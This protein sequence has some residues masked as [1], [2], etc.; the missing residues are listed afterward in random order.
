[1]NNFNKA[2]EF[3]EEKI[4]NSE[5]ITN[6]D[7][8]DVCGYEQHYCSKIFQKYANMNIQEYIKRRK[9]SFA[10]GDLVT[11][12]K[13]IADIAEKYLYSADGFTKAFKDTFGITPIQLKRKEKTEVLID[14]F[15][16]PIYIEDYSQYISEPKDFVIREIEEMKFIGISDIDILSDNIEKIE[17]DFEYM[18][19]INENGKRFELSYILDNEKKLR[20]TFYANYY[21]PFSYYPKE[22]RIIK[23][24]KQKWIAL[25]AEG[26]DDKFFIIS[27]IKS[28]FYN[29]WLKKHKEYELDDNYEIAF[30]CYN[31]EYFDNNDPI[32]RCEVWFPIKEKK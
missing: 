1:M 30:E 21:T 29:E 14:N 22:F 9:M 13:N 23:V 12:K 32:T 11:S 3:I 10:F 16:N 8:A 24:P 18:S 27:A 6:K 28:Y 7:V 19:I 4:K 2:I 26:I 17:N 25:N 15:M 5:E 31:N 20:D